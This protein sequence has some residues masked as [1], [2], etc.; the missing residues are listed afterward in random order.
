MALPLEYR[1]VGSRRGAWPGGNALRPGPFK[2]SGLRFGQGERKAHRRPLTGLALGPDAPTVGVEDGL[3]DGQSQAAAVRGG[4]F[5]S[6]IKALEHVGQRLRR[7]AFSRIAHARP[8]FS[9]GGL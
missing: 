8:C 2:G 1:C 4:R 7:D 3:G 9:V 6:A 5:R